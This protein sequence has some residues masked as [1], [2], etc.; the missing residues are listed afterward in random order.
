MNND[1]INEWDKAA[2]EYSRS[3]ENSP[4]SLFNKKYVKSLL[5]RDLHGLSIL[6]AGCGDG[7]YANFFMSREQM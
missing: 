3:Q 7:Y 5:V 2:A 1:S 4:Y 6:D